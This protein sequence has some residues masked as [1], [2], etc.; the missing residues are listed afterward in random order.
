MASDYAFIAFPIQNAQKV[1]EG[2]LPKEDLGV[3]AIDSS[4]LEI[5]LE[6]PT[7]YFLESLGTMPHF[8]PIRNDYLGMYGESYGSDEERMA[9]NGPFVMQAWNKGEK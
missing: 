4:I 5:V 6:N 2:I 7:N 9:Y 3:T 8:S 1:Y